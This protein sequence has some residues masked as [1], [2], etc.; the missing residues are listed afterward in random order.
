MS[1]VRVIWKLIY[2]SS[3]QS[4]TIVQSANI[5]AGIL[6][7][8]TALPA[9]SVESV[10]SVQR[11]T[12]SMTEA[13]RM[14]TDRVQVTALVKTQQGFPQGGDYGNLVTIMN[15]ILA[16][17]VNQSG[18]INGITVDSILPDIEGPDLFVDNPSIL[19]RSRDFMVRWVP[20]S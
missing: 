9:I 16:A 15:F 17:C 12:L 3:L 5:R 4:P 14:H 6:P 19:T 8:D 10:S 7:I 18:V 20:A 1:G 13:R 2:D 11:Q